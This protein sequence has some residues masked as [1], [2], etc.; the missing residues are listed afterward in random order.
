MRDDVRLPV[1][2]H[3]RCAKVRT[4]FLSVSV[5]LE[6]QSSG[7]IE[8]LQ[9]EPYIFGG[10]V[11]IGI[12]VRIIGK[13]HLQYFAGQFSFQGIPGTASQFDGNSATYVSVKLLGVID[14]LSLRKGPT[15]ELTL[16]ESRSVEL[17]LIQGSL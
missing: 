14:A 15:G 13:C 6:T 5:S 11:A 4:L 9:L 7:Q 8:W 12:L 3:S 16:Y 1:A 10:I 2:C 17:G